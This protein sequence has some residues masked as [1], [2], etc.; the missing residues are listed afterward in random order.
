[1]QQL[2]LAQGETLMVTLKRSMSFVRRRL[3][4]LV[5]GWLILQGTALF[6]APLTFSAANVSAEDVACDCPD[7]MPGAQCPMHKSRAADHDDETRCSM[8]SALLPTDLALLSLTPTGAVP[9]AQVVEQVATTFETI[10]TGD[11]AVVSHTDLPDS[12]PPRS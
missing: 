2:T 10:T 7:A 12:P 4:W 3:S 5:T 11:R 8:R 1:V 6:A 9:V